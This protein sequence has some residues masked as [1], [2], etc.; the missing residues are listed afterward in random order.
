MKYE[1]DFERE[2]DDIVRELEV[3]KQNKVSKLKKKF[4]NKQDFKIGEIIY[5]L[6]E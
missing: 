1:E 3:L 2:Y 5:M 6:L 4:A